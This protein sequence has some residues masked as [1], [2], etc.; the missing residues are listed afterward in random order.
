MGSQGNSQ[1]ALCPWLEFIQGFKGVQKINWEHLKLFRLWNTNI[2]WAIS[3]GLLTFSWA[4]HFSGWLENI[5]NLFL[6]HLRKTSTYIVRCCPPGIS[7]NLKGWLALLFLNKTSEV[8]VLDYQLCVAYCTLQNVA[9]SAKDSEL[10]M[11]APP[12]WRS[13]LNVRRDPRLGITQSASKIFEIPA[14]ITV[15]AEF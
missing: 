9:F 5:N 11:S 8:V 10:I 4:I 3:F 14:R 13:V 7:N 2:F 1:M 6:S 12:P 15:Q